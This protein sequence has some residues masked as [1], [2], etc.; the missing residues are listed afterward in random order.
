M[1]R[2]A[3]VQPAQERLGSGF[4]RLWTAS[5]AGNLGDGVGR[6]AL[7]LLAARLTDD[8]VAFS[9]I[10]ALGY[11]PW[12][13][14]G[15]PA[16]ALVDRY[17]RRRLSVL[18]GTVRAVTIAVLLVAVAADTASIWLLYAIVVVLGACET[19]YDNAIIAMVATVVE[20]RD[21]LE[22]AN[23]RMQGAE[24]VSQGFVGPPVASALFAAAAAW[25]FG[26]QVA[27]FAL[28]VLL[29][30]KIPGQ[31][32]PIGDRPS[33]PMRRAMGEA[34]RYVASHS[35]HRSILAILLV[36]GLCNA[37]ATAVTVLWAREVLGVAEA[38][39][40]VFILGGT[41]GAF[42]G[43][44]TAAPIARRIGRGRTMVLSVAVT[45]AAS[46]GT[47]ATKSPYVAA[48]AMAATGWAIL[49]WN[50][51]AGSLR[52]RL[53]PDALLGRTVGIYRVVTWGIMPLGAL[54][55]GIIADLAGLR[56]PI[57]V[58][59]ALTLAVAAF[60]AVRLT[61]RRVDTAI[62]EADARTEADADAA[63]RPAGKAGADTDA[64]AGT[65]GKAGADTDA[66]AG[67]VGKA[68]ADTDAAAGTTGQ[69]GADVDAA[70][71][72]EARDH[73]ESAGA[74]SAGTPPMPAAPAS[75]AAHVEAPVAG[76][77]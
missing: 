19:M 51:V 23:G 35:W 32:H 4:N 41:V 31:F 42:I 8:P 70:A 43:S 1:R 52:Q 57:A 34:I 3:R 24:L 14:L 56:A 73:A 67:T 10:A 61:N 26:L 11:V 71:D 66:A 75:G 7:A 17:D 5:A 46:I 55:G 72:A 15:L 40:G 60:A 22:S 53:T 48:A 39:F 20:D 49:L 58:S 63:A 9:A 12:L 38:A 77:P 25:A 37:M 47:A 69:A 36:I 65:V 27:C 6:V 16:G 59:G 54:L 50:V 68:G 29:L 2:R 21:R 76:A 18:T 64:A 30:F 45:G 28:A 74:P 44:Q 33:T 13:V 62:A